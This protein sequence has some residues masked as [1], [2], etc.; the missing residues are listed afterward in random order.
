LNQFPLPNVWALLFFL[1]LF[2][3]GIDS[4]FGTMQGV[5]QAPI[6]LNTS[7]LQVYKSA[8]FEDNY[9]YFFCKLRLKAAFKICPERSNP[10]HYS[11]E[12]FDDHVFCSGSASSI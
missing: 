6:Q 4:Q 9:K 12:C 11:F 10:V 2:T 3:L 8:I 7:F 5:V 1:M